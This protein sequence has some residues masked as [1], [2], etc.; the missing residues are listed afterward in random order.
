MTTNKTTLERA[1]ELAE[2]GEVN[3]TEDIRKQLRREGFDTRQIEGQ[4][5][6]RQ[7]MDASRKARA[8]PKQS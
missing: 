1:F 3:S 8:Q 6:C 5:L 4:S 2:T 7:L